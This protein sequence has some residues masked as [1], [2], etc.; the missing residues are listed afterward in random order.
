MKQWFIHWWCLTSDHNHIISYIAVMKHWWRTTTSIYESILID[1]NDY[2]PVINMRMTPL[3]RHSVGVP[4]CCETPAVF[5]PG[6]DLREWNSTWLSIVK[7]QLNLP[8]LESIWYATR[9]WTSQ[10][11]TTGRILLTKSGQS[12]TFINSWLIE[13]LMG[14]LPIWDDT[15]RLLVI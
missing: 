12:W 11:L 14:W 9:L 6:S 10:H 7:L 15:D 4:Q 5:S 1:G 3:E 8:G 2:Q 13:H